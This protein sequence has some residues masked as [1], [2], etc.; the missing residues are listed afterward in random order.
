M[1]VVFLLSMQVRSTPSSLEIGN[2]FIFELVIRS[3]C[4]SLIDCRHSLLE[5][6]HVCD[7]VAQS[8]ILYEPLP[9]Y[10]VT[11]PHSA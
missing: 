10:V 6:S 1:S 4:C 2:Y 7:K 3:Y 11:N 5:Y 8:L 9:G